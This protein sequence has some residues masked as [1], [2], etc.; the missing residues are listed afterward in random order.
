MDT[1]ALD[2]AQLS[3]YTV[4]QLEDA[5]SSLQ[6]EE[7][8]LSGQAVGIEAQL[9]DVRMVRQQVRDRIVLLRA[10]IASRNKAQG[11]SQQETAKQLGVSQ[12]TVSN[13]VQAAKKAAETGK[14]PADVSNSL[15]HKPASTNG[16]SN[17]QPNQSV[18]LS[19]QDAADK[20]AV[21]LIQAM[22][23]FAHKVAKLHTQL[24]PVSE[25]RQERVRFALSLCDVEWP[26]IRSYAE[27]G[28]SDFD[29]GI[30]GILGGSQGE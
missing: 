16:V 11:L 1:A 27:T 12:Q 22:E 14:S 9:A 23:S 25:Q 2:F 15:A 30:A 29:A 20:A 26:W 5:L 17:S 13:N 7:A 21:E 24:G 10:E 19:P 8:Q 3:Q 28:M 4:P 6:N 18:T